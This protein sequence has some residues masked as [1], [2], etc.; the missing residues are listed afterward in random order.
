MTSPSDFNKTSSQLDREI[1]GVLEHLHRSLDSSQGDVETKGRAIVSILLASLVFLTILG[2]QYLFSPTGR[3]E[4]TAKE[5][6]LLDIHILATREKQLLVTHL[7]RV[8]A[9]AQRIREIRNRVAPNM[10]IDAQLSTI[11]NA[12]IDATA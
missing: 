8:R 7:D 12:A 9:E 1:T 4:R 2:F 3:V 10:L 11:E 6:D 5:Q